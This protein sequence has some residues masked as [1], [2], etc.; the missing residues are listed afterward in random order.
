MTFIQY[1]CFI[2]LDPRLR[3]GSEFDWAACEFD[4]EHV[5]H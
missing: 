1:D 2:S 4:N 3:A 5:M